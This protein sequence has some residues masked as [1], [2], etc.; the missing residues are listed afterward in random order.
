MHVHVHTPGIYAQDVSLGI[1]SPVLYLKVGFDFAKIR[2]LTNVARRL[3]CNQTFG[4]RSRAHFLEGRIH[5]LK[6]W[7]VA[8]FRGSKSTSQKYGRFHVVAP[9]ADL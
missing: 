3:T 4:D 5:L 7:Q 9:S 2:A 8:H 1:N 6:H